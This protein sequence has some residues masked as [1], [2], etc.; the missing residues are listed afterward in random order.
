MLQNIEQLSLHVLWIFRVFISISIYVMMFG[1]VIFLQGPRRRVQQ[2]SLKVLEKVWLVQQPDLQ[3]ALLTWPAV[4]SKGSRGMVSVNGFCMY[5]M[6]SHDCATVCI[7][8]CIYNASMYSD[9]WCKY[10]KVVLEHFIASADHLAVAESLYVCVCMYMNVCV[11]Q[12][13]C[14]YAFIQWVELF[15]LGLTILLNLVHKIQQAYFRHLLL[16]ILR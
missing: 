4:R 5:S 14:L 9:G 7:L 1:D 16:F 11:P 13:Y 8:Q 15:R 2:A 10:M 12:Y 6:C 3:G